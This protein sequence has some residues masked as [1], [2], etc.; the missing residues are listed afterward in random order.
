MKPLSRRGPRRK[1]PVT[2]RLHAS[3]VGTEPP[4]F[5]WLE[6]SSELFLNDLHEVIGASFGWVDRASHEFRCGPAFDD[7]TMERYICPEAVEDGD[8]AVPEEQVRLDELI[9]TPGDTL[10]YLYDFADLW[11]H[12]MVLDEIKPRT[13]KM[14]RARCAGGMRDCPVDVYGGV[15]KY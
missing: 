12:H 11:V 8:T 14:P 7:P 15:A 3:I 4:L 13:A 2:F 9:T 6:V 1:R 5:R 10:F